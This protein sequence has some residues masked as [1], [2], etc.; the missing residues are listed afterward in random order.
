[1]CHTSEKMNCYLAFNNP[2]KVAKIYKEGCI[3]LLLQIL[4][5]VRIPN[6]W[7]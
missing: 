4:F 2:L 1:L 7:H 6:V 3:A 5:V